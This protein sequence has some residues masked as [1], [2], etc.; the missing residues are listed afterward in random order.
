MGEKFVNHE[1]QPVKPDLQVLCL[2]SSAWG[3]ESGVGPP[4]E[5]PLDP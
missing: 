3:T 2:G 1:A 4:L 5:Q